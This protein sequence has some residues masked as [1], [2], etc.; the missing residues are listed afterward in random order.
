MSAKK[1]EAPES[2]QQDQKTFEQ[3]LAE[4]EAIVRHLEEGEAPLAQ[5]LG[6]YESG[7]RLLKHCY[8]LLESA[9]RRIELLRGL[10]ADGQPIVE[11]LDDAALSLE[12]KAQARSRRRS[13]DA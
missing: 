6:D 7:V 13:R 1:N 11:A 5:A 4:L 12:E 9:E 8:G 10:D 3:G 2:D